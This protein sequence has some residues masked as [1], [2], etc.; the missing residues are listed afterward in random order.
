MAN[1]TIN[2]K[3]FTLDVEPDT[4]LLWAIR[5]NAGLTGTKY[6]CGI[7]QCGAC[8]VHI[9]GVATRSCGVSVSE[10]EG[11]KITTIEGLASGDALHKVQE[12][13]IAQD[14]P[15]CGYC[16]SGMIM[17]VAAL[18]SEKPKPT[19]ADIDEAITN[20]CR[21]GTFQQVREAIHTI[22]SA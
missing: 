13:W 7:A 11:K 17:A 8:T 6:G 5:E 2:G 16:Q 20:I 21:C 10:A 12:A 18:L 15:Q 4:P 22:A 1:L 14:V 9:E 3:T 19:D